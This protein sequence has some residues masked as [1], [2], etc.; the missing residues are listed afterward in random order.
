MVEVR[1]IAK[2][3]RTS[4][5]NRRILDSLR[6]FLRT[7]NRLTTMSGFDAGWDAS[8]NPMFGARPTDRPRSPTESESSDGTT[9]HNSAER[10]LPIRPSNSFGVTDPPSINPTIP[11]ARSSPARNIGSSATPQGVQQRSNNAGFANMRNAPK[12]QIPSFDPR[13][14]DPEQW[15][16]YFENECELYGF[17]RKMM[18]TLLGKAILKAVEHDGPSKTFWRNT[19][20]Q[21]HDY[22]GLKKEFVTF[23]EDDVRVD[24]DYE[25]VLSE[26]SQSTLTARQYKVYFDSTLHKATRVRRATGLPSYDDKVVLRY[27]LDGITDDTARASVWGARPANWAEAAFTLENYEKQIPRRR[28]DMVW[29]TKK[30]VFRGRKGGVEYPT[31][32]RGEETDDRPYRR[33]RVIMDMEYD[34]RIAELEQREEELE[35][36]MRNLA[37]APNVAT[38]PA[39]IPQRR[40]DT[41]PPSD[42]NEGTLSA[43]VDELVDRFAKL[44]IYLGKNAKENVV[45][46]PTDER[47][48]PYQQRT[49]DQRYN[50]Y[51]PR[52]DI[53]NIR[54]FKCGELGHYATACQSERKVD[55]AHVARLERERNTNNFRPDEAPRK[56]FW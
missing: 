29:N 5:E 9:R 46:N 39:V 53:S 26:I 27:F 20:M 19:V 41:P 32:P 7:T 40:N 52:R 28:R 30:D 34:Q 21:C 18:K 44:E 49:G 3:L 55:V 47:R 45:P 36:R 24:M 2:D 31:T 6:T 17:D 38:V 14:D 50:Q 25:R 22:T 12:F 10:R 1:G 42:R 15:L 43:K 35:R 48:A 54:C 4:L 56:D 8:P 11:G 37:L 16:D 51:P 13:D 33:N 23:Y